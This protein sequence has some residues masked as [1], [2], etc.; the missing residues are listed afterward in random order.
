MTASLNRDFLL[1]GSFNA[2][3]I[4]KHDPTNILEGL[5]YAFS[6]G[7]STNMIEKSIHSFLIDQCKICGSDIQS[8]LLHMLRCDGN[9]VNSC[10]E[11]KLLN[12][13][14]TYTN[15]LLLIILFVKSMCSI[16]CRKIRLHFYH[17]IETLPKFEEYG[18]QNHLETKYDIAIL[19]IDMKYLIYVVDKK[20]LGKRK[21][22]F[23]NERDQDILKSIMFRNPHLRARDVAIK[24]LEDNAVALQEV[25]SVIEKVYSIKRKRTKGEQCAE[26]CDPNVC[27]DLVSKAYKKYCREI[28]DTP[29][30]SCSLCKRLHFQK[31]LKKET[32]NSEDIFT[33]SFCLCKNPSRATR[34]YQTLASTGVS[35]KIDA[36]VALSSF[37]AR[38]LSLRIPFAKIKQLNYEGQY[39]MRGSVVNVMAD[40]E[41]VQNILPR[42][43]HEDANVLVGIKR[44]LEYDH[45]YM[46]GTVRPLQTMKAMHALMRT[47]LYIQENVKVNEEWR[48][49]ID[50][51]LA[52]AIQVQEPTFDGD[53]E[54]EG[55]TD[56][57]LHG[58]YCSEQVVDHNDSILNV[59]PSEGFTP[60]GLLTDNYCEELCFPQLYFGT[61]CKY[62]DLRK[63]HYQLIVKWELTHESTQFSTNIENLFFKAMKV[64]VQKV[65][66][67]TWV[68]L[69]KG[70]LGHTVLHAKDVQDDTNIDR[71]LHS[72]IGFRDFDS[73]RTS[74]DYKQKQKKNVFAM[75]RQLGP[76][77]FFVTFSSAERRW[78]ELIACLEKLHAQHRT[79][80]QRS[81]NERRLL[82]MD[83]VTCT[84]YYV[85]RFQ[86][87]KKLLKHDSSILGQIDDFYF[88]TE[89][90]SRGSQHDHGLLWIK[91][92]PSLDTHTD[93]QVKTFI[94]SY[95]TTN[96]DLLPNDLQDVH[97]HRHRSTCYKRGGKCRFQFPRP[98]MIETKILR[99]LLE[100]EKDINFMP[101]AKKKHIKQTIENLPRSSIITI[102]QWLEDAHIEMDEYIYYLRSKISSPTIYLKRSMKDIYTNNF[103]VQLARLWNANTD[104]QY[105]LNAYGAAS[106]CTSYMT[107]L[108]TTMM[109]VIK[110]QVDWC[111][112][113]NAST[114]D[115]LRRVGNAILNG[116]QLT[117][118]QAVYICL[119]L[120]L[121]SSTREII[122][123]NTSPLTERTL[124]LKR[125]Y[126][127]A[128]LDSESKEVF[129]DTIITKYCKRHISLHKLCLADF[130]T[131]FNTNKAATSKR[132]RQKILRYVH[133][134]KQ[135]DP[136]NYYREQCLLYL[137]FGTSEEEHLQTNENWREVYKRNE[138]LINSNACK[139]TKT[140]YAFE[141]HADASSSVD[142]NTRSNSTV[143]KY[144]IVHEI[145]GLDAKKPVHLPK[146]K[147]I[148][149]MENPEFYAGIRAL[150]SEQRELLDD[151]TLR[152]KIAPAI[153]I[154]LFLTG[155]AGTGKTH[156][157]LLLVQALQRLY[158]QKKQFD[159]EKP[160]VL[161]MAYTGKA[162]YNIG[163]LTIHSA[164]HLP[165]VTK[166]HTSLSTEK[167]NIL[168]D[169]YQNLA[170]VVFDEVSLI[171]A[172][173]FSLADSRLRQILH[174]HNEPFGGVDVIL[175]G[176]L[177]QASPVRDKWIFSQQA[178][179]IESITPSY[180]HS[181]PKC[182]ELT[183]PM[184]QKNLDYINILNRI[185]IGQHTNEDIKRI[186][187][188]YM[189]I[190]IHDKDIAHLYFTNEDKDKHNEKNFQETL[191]Q[192]FILEAQDYRHSSCSTK[193][194]IPT[195]A[196]DT[197]GLHTTLK[198][199]PSMIIEICSGNLDI[200]DG[201]VNGAE[202]NFM[203]LIEP[204]S[205]IIWIQFKDRRIG[206]GTRQE[207]LTLY[208][209]NTP[210]TWT[211][212]R[213]ISKEIQIGHN[214]LN[215]ITRTQFPIQPASARTI[216]RAQGLSMDSL[217]FEPKKIR[218][219]G[220]IYTALSRVRDPNNL[221]ILSELH[222]E[223]IKVDTTVLEEIKRLHTCARWISL[224]RQMKRLPKN[225]IKIQSLNTVSLSAH[226]ENIKADENIMASHILTLQE[227][228]ILPHVQ[229]E[230]NKMTQ[231]AT[232]GD[233]G[234]IV[235]THEDVN[236]FSTKVYIGTGVE[237]LHLTLQIQNSILNLITLYKSPTAKLGTFLN[238]LAEAMQNTN[239]QYIHICMGDFNIDARKNT[240]A[241]T[242]L[243]TLMKKNNMIL[244]DKQPTTIYGSALDHIWTSETLTNISFGI[245]NCY[246]SDHL[247]PYLLLHS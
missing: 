213:K 182:F 187:N 230:L 6:L 179:L 198:L 24:Y 40:I 63:K 131:M 240:T 95:V 108:D 43:L 164:L 94:D 197:A 8:S 146:T 223:Q 116:Q 222:K 190:P 117:A 211:P 152:K 149:L 218:T 243:E 173:T 57:L 2:H 118:Q 38:L 189:R 184:R 234:I 137:P 112:N 20:N 34:I 196:K 78:R 237:I 159:H 170:L 153:P 174:N 79:S 36:V 102:D 202:G 113:N 157:L 87:L 111:I 53:D 76:P 3:F 239:K 98:P 33:C 155:G 221:Y 59:A 31:H 151:I 85:H 39:G 91:D 178:Q 191:G 19:Y 56:V 216:H 180:W 115:R 242:A 236:I 104:V 32:I 101:S 172:N 64:M 103:N 47:P 114:L 14:H 83:P 139:Y 125:K 58:L 15:S 129:C 244:L 166:A 145:P 12:M 228:R 207:N 13:L 55:N 219:H 206:H 25:N 194:Q 141:H 23:W 148:V 127:L 130:A 181:Y 105:I 161:L 186:N 212:I 49:H 96:T 142:T 143:H 133:Y 162:A 200:L 123:I 204:Q 192:I 132:K 217:A 106:Y 81:Q 60:L 119:S 203:G 238:L 37:E 171:G 61:P 26:R 41:R 195:N 209:S 18:D 177:C 225:T 62:H 75:I 10:I 88:V 136:D 158:L 72:R 167:L 169:R 229:Y 215:I 165:I 109:K 86:A 71:M 126:L 4:S 42:F 69:R 224:H 107:K 74:P 124:L 110:E 90:Q 16:C 163:G 144:D 134:N 46:T 183:I 156:T 77:T 28:M 138:T 11:S 233:H 193:I 89:F 35:D 128:N 199:K 231:T 176:D 220:L 201:L 48:Q 80:E 122:F 68:R 44:K 17:S 93:D 120:P 188:Q 52:T 9:D 205:D 70:K 54:Y 150:N 140:S 247:I 21:K 246:W 92:A 73:L 232:Y 226:I 208:T 185:R 45:Y 160:H 135:K 22:S 147:S 50:N 84:R 154:H 82:C 29:Q 168:S 245:N 27:S 214:M 65:I 235:Y 1:K 97:I 30:N 121:H 7:R 241:F 210:R 99:P 175:C 51:I 5:K 227:T 67:S 100:N 66:E